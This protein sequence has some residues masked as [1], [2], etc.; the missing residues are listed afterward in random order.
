[1]LGC[2]LCRH[3]IVANRRIVME[4]IFG[5]PRSLGSVRRAGSKL[6]LFRTSFGTLISL[7]IVVG[8]LVSA[9]GA[10]SPASIETVVKEV[11]VEK[12]VTRVVLATPEQV[13]E[14]S[15]SVPI[16]A[17]DSLVLGGTLRLGTQ[18]PVVLFDPIHTQDNNS[19]WAEL[20]IFEHLARIGA[21]ASSIEPA[22]A[23]SWTINST[24]DV[25]SFKIRQGMKF[26]N[27]EPVMIED[28]KFSLDRCRA[29]EATVSWILEA[30]KDIKIVDSSTLE[31]ALT[32]PSA[33]FLNDIVLWG[34]GIYPEAYVKKVGDE[35]FA[36][37][38]IGSGPFMVSEWVKGQR[39]VLKRNPFY[40]GKDA[41]GNSLPY[42]D[43]VI[44][45]EITEDNTRVLKLLA[46]ELDAVTSVPGSLVDTLK[47][48]P[49]LTVVAA[50]AAG[51]NA[52]ALNQRVPALQDVKVRQALKYAVDKQA[53]VDAVFFGYAQPSMSAI[54][55][56]VW[57][58]TE[59]YGQKFDLDKAK[60]LMAGSKF[61][62]G[63]KVSLMLGAGNS[64]SEQIAN[65]VKE[66]W[67][68]I[69]VEVT[70]EPTESGLA[71]E[72]RTKKDYDINLGGFGTAD[73]IDPNSNWLYGYISDGGAEAGRTGWKDAEMD[74]LF[75][76][77]QS[78]M[79]F[80]KRCD[81]YDKLQEIAAERGPSVG[82]VNMMAIYAFKPSVH[83]F[84]ILPTFNWRLWEVW[85]SK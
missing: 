44:L 49:D 50:P 26:S 54:F 47:K 16:V 80:G 17:A 4:Y 28:V 30:V 68:A 59:K 70:L 60:A 40:Y 67:K 32:T 2:M 1:M 41:S 35:V 84:K 77:S 78:E 11:V 24:G 33:A 39:V 42:L 56:G 46:G 48:A 79:D 81:I 21:D 43:Q 63:F 76:K 82:L 66:Q 27:G 38:P 25:W 3:T 52:I 20:N 9:C 10:A 61:P 57:C 55:P 12:E 15:T 23:E 85:V 83:G 74:T 58:M 14:V 5:K 72:R 6:R 53:I 65:I 37:K 45:E 19:L 69:N 29:P 64:V 13:V 71:W 22:V 51:G 73:N 18:E 7:A 75:R 62:D 34:C 36:E 8:T 31:I